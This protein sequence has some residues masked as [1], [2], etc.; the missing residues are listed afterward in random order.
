MRMFRWS[1]SRASQR[2]GVN[3]H[4]PPEP[5]TAL[6]PSSCC[7]TRG[8]FATQKGA[9]RERVTRPPAAR[10]TPFAP[11][12][13]QMTTRVE[14]DSCRAIGASKLR[15]TRS[16]S[17]LATALVTAAAR[18]VPST[19]PLTPGTALPRP[20]VVEISISISISVVR[21]ARHTSYSQCAPFPNRP[22]HEAPR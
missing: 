20:T 11:L 19:A 10:S 2:P 9:Q 22:M 7:A 15:R 18:R 1:R 13:R 5:W 21:V 16:P 3:S 14:R 17:A 12:G 8:Y 6:S 4:R